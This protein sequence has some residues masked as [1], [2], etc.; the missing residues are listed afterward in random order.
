MASE[1]FVGG[2]YVPSSSPTSVGGNGYPA[3][4]LGANPPNVPNGRAMRARHNRGSNVRLPYARIVPL[5]E[6][7]EE[8][9]TGPSG[10]KLRTEP[11]YQREAHPRT[12][13]VNGVAAL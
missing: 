6:P 4:G 11:G 8:P 13:M 7:R 10:P 1:A 12:V 5:H 3:P 9:R 2:A